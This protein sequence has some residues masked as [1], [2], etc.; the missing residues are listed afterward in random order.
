MPRPIDLL[1]KRLNSTTVQHLEYRATNRSSF[2]LLSIDSEITLSIAILCLEIRSIYIRLIF[3]EM[4]KT[5]YLT[6]FIYKSANTDRVIV[7]YGSD[8]VPFIIVRS[9]DRLSDFC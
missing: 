5:H 1:N 9:S 3:K 7:E 6:L 4:R 8:D 2:P